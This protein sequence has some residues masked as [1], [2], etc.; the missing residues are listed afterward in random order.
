[1]PW[2]CQWIDAVA[3]AET[4]ISLFNIFIQRKDVKRER[5]KEDNLRGVTAD[6]EGCSRCSNEWLTAIPPES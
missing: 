1:M 5:E 4:F 2:T 6:E 3:M